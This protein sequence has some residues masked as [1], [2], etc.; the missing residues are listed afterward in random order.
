MVVSSGPQG[1]RAFEEVV[2][3]HSA[4]AAMLLHPVD[5]VV[6]ASPAMEYVT[7]L[8]DSEFLG[9][10]AADWVHPDDVELA[11]Q[12]RH[13]ASLAGH[14]GPTVLRGRHGEGGYR[15]FEA[16]WWHLATEHTVLHLRDVEARCVVIDQLQADLA[17]AQ[18][19][20]RD[21]GADTDA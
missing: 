13:L 16:E 1:V 3:R 8:P 14:S 18:A 21:L 5:G 9:N 6:Y 2:L 19:R 10:L 12:Q 20:L 15:R 4:D 7:G 17:A 11:I